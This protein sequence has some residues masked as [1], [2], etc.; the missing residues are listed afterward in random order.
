MTPSETASIRA[1]ALFA[2]PLHRSSEP[3][4]VEIR[5]A[6]LATLRLRGAAGC[7]A[8]VAAEYGDHPHEAVARMCWALA[9]T[10]TA[11]PSHRRVV[12]LTPARNMAGAA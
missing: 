7:A 5:A 11:Y 3:G 2:S 8:I 9:A 6:V 12:C 1:E 10:E 4:P